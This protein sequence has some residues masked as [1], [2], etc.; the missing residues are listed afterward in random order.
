[1]ARGWE[2]KSVESQMEDRERTSHPA[3]GN[4]HPDAGRE[5]ELALLRLSLTRLKQESEAISNPR[6][7]ILKQRAIAHLERRIEEASR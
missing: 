1:V 6:L 5:R 4:L 3:G 2:S 7:L